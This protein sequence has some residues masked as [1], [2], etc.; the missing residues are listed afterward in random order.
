MTLVVHQPVSS[1]IVYLKKE[2]HQQHLL[3]YFISMQ[4]LKLSRM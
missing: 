2:Y 1:C 3:P 4:Y